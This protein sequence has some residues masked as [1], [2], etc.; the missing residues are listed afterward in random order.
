MHVHAKRSFSKLDVAFLSFGEA[1]TDLASESF[2][3]H[4]QALL[5][6]K[7]EGEMRSEGFGL[8]ASWIESTASCRWL[9]LGVG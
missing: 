7:A 5:E 8:V 3:W 4:S 1:G 9:C 6:P 2:F